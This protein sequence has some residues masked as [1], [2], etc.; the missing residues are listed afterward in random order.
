MTEKELERATKE[1][2]RDYAR[3][4]RKR[5]PDKVKAANA[6]Y[7]AKKALALAAEKEGVQ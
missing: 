1:A 7:W 3:E 5:N 6:R 4:W 2:K